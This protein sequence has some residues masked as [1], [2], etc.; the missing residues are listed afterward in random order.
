MSGRLQRLA[1]HAFPSSVWGH[2]GLSAHYHNQIQTRPASGQL[3]AQ[4]AESK[5]WEQ[6]VSIDM[7]ATCGWPAGV[8][9]TK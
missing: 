3:H 7:A 4:H 5:V 1:R 9:D 8:A 6:P 2:V